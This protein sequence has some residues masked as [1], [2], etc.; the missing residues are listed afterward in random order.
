MAIQNPL[1][2]STIN[3]I[4]DSATIV[5]FTYHRVLSVIQWIVIEIIHRII[6]IVKVSI[7]NCSIYNIRLISIINDMDK[8]QSGIQ[9]I[10]MFITFISL[11]LHVLLEKK[12][13]DLKDSWVKEQEY[14]KTELIVNDSE[15]WQT[16]RYF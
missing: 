3:Y 9:S 13:E 15:P 4:N 6:P 7:L 10:Q 12:L 2:S 16:G 8:I 1:F 14:L 11:T 5:P